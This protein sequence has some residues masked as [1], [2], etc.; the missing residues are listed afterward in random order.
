MKNI[1]KKEIIAHI[2]ETMA[3]LV[4]GRRENGCKIYR[5]SYL[6]YD[7]LRFAPV[8]GYT[9][10]EVEN[11]PAK[12][13]E[14]TEKKYFIAFILAYKKPNQEKTY[15]YEFGYNSRKKETATP[16][17]FIYCCGGFG[18]EL[19]KEYNA[20]IYA[21]YNKQIEETEKAI[22]KHFERA[23]QGARF[24]TR[25]RQ[26]IGENFCFWDF[27][28][29]SGSAERVETYGK[30]NQSG[31]F[32][33][34][35]GNEIDSFKNV[36]DIVAKSFDKSGYFAELWR[37]E[38]RQRA[39]NLRREKARKKAEENAEKWEK[40]DKSEAKQKIMFFV[41]DYYKNMYFS[42]VK[43]QIKTNR[44]DFYARTF[45]KELG[46]VINRTI[47]SAEKIEKRFSSFEEVAKYFE[48]LKK[49]INKIAMLGAL[50]ERN[51]KTAQ[52]AY[53]WDWWELNEK[54][55]LV[56]TYK[57]RKEKEY[58]SKIFIKNGVVCGTF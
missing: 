54:N 46:G 53:G 13:I 15:Y 26:K 4:K 17:Y 35:N 18:R 9:L 25:E 3:E 8:S 1:T 10:E 51:E 55:E 27:C 52:F 5:G 38:L 57:G 11:K 28:H 6:V 34:I 30:M 22:S 56:N 21:V 19:A 33:K 50:V 29:Y 49:L 45:A 40:A 31:T 20:K 42:F 41:N 39:Q 32:L 24:E 47:E 12:L 16:Y 23:K 2:S 7:V 14:A 36:N 37:E 43:W 48:K 44:F 58:F